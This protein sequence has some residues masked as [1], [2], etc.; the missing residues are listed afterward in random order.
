MP[1]VLGAVLEYALTTCA[2]LLRYLS[3]LPNDC[4]LC[5]VAGTNSPILAPFR[6]QGACSAHLNIEACMCT[7]PFCTKKALTG[8][9]N[10]AAKESMPQATEL[11][12]PPTTT[13]RDTTNNGRSRRRP[14]ATI[15]ATNQSTE[16]NM[17]GQLGTW[18]VAGPSREAKHQLRT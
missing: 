11:C 12:K 7:R 8:D 5:V 18:H 15:V 9:E 10:P 17:D 14:K 2:Y 16:V 4:F 13:H 3:T 1:Y 6:H